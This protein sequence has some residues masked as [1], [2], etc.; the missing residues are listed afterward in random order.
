VDPPSVS[1]KTFALRLLFMRE[2][3]LLDEVAKVEATAEVV[4]VEGFDVVDVEVSLGMFERAGSF[5][6]DAD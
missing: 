2:S 5:E 4:V 6:V 1:P 3:I